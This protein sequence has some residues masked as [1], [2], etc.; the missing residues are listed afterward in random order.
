MPDLIAAGIPPTCASGGHLVQPLPFVGEQLKRQHVVWGNLVPGRFQFHERRKIKIISSF[1]HDVAVDGASREK[2]DDPPQ[3]K[4]GW[5]MEESRRHAIVG[6]S[7]A[8]YQ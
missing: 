6:F 2:D 4:G 1:E 3:E 8:K 7:A 5:N